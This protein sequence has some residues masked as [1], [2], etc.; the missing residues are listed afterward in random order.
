VRKRVI[1][2][3]IQHFKSSILM[4]LLANLLSAIGYVLAAVLW[5]YKI[6]ILASVLISWVNADPYNVLLTV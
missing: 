5:F 6:V 2:G 1:L 4:I 3:D